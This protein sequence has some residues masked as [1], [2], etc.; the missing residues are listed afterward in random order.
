MKERLPIAL[1]F[2]EE[3]SGTLL[4]IFRRS[5][6]HAV[7]IN[8]SKNLYHTLHTALFSSLKRTA[9]AHEQQG[10]VSK[11][12]SPTASSVAKPM[13]HAS[14]Q[15]H[16]REAQEQLLFCPPP[17]TPYTQKM[18]SPSQYTQRCT[19]QNLR[20]S[21]GYISQWIGTRVVSAS[22][23]PR[24][25]LSTSYS[26]AT[27]PFNMWCEVAVWGEVARRW[28]SGNSFLKPQTSVST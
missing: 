28:L 12:V 4:Q 11:H 16:K 1:A 10:K 7:C 17:I 9:Y 14:Q 26:S 19:K 27:L 3:R 13:G 5:F 21:I 18:G 15:E 20:H 22:E 23:K 2:V 8:W 6:K 24:R 25:A